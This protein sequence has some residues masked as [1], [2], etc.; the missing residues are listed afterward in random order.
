MGGLGGLGGHNHHVFV[1]SSVAL[2]MCVNIGVSVLNIVMQ[3]GGDYNSYQT[4]SCVFLV[5]GRTVAA[6]LSLKFLLYADHLDFHCQRF[7]FFL[8][9]RFVLIMWCNSGERSTQII[10]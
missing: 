4:Q 9:I 3:H 10:C 1:V 6:S 7:S 5:K 8:S 2:T